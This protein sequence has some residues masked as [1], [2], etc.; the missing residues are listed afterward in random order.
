MCESSGLICQ[1]FIFI[2][3][4]YPDIHDLGQTGAIVPSLMEDFS[5]K[6]YTVFAENYYN[7]V[8][9]TNFMS[10]KETCRFGTLKSD[11]KG[12]PRESVD[13]KLKKGEVVV[14]LS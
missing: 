10:R 6:G 12:N 1:S 9:L 8:K 7:S 11:W 14:K 2:G 5:G 3:L 4:S 13:K